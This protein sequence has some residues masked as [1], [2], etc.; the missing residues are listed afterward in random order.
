MNKIISLFLCI[1]FAFS[2]S[3]CGTS[4]MEYERVQLTKDNY[5][6]YINID[7]YISDYSFIISEQT[8]LITK[9]DL[10]VV[11]HIETSKKVDCTF[12]NVSITYSPFY[13]P[14][15]QY[16]YRVSSP[17]A[18]LNLEGESHIFYAATMEK[19]PSINNSTKVLTSTY[20]I[21][22]SVEGFVVV[23]KEK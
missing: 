13:T 12:E 14:L 5:S 19:S 4:E 9:Y 6:D 1:A 15:W 21:V 11:V 20:D 18:T 2:L 10:S 16:T 17:N 8:N 3:A 7:A 23:P 22:Q